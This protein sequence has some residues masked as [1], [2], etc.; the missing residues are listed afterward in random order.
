[1]AKVRR[2]RP[3]FAYKI[4][5][6][7]NV[8]IVNY[9]GTFVSTIN[10]DIPELSCT[11]LRGLLESLPW[12]VNL[13][14]QKKEGGLLSQIMIDTLTVNFPVHS[15]LQIITIKRQFSLFFIAGADDDDE[16]FGGEIDHS[17]FADAGIFE[18]PSAQK[19]LEHLTSEIESHM[20]TARFGLGETR[21]THLP[22]SDEAAETEQTTDRRFAVDQQQS[23]P[24]TTAP[25]TSTTTTI[26]EQTALSMGPTLTGLPTV[27]VTTSRIGMTTIPGESTTLI[28]NES[29]A[30]ALPP[31]DTTS[32]TGAEPKRYIYI[33]M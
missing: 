5:L 9:L 30:F 4:N 11:E 22:Q 33:Y 6:V 7:D 20:D 10:F 21:T 25:E 28:T 15:V 12:V 27:G 17:L 18:D 3:T 29:E 23:Q 2:I 13:T 1:M 16:N 32:V 14:T 19:Q 8:C 31:I 24:T 26:G